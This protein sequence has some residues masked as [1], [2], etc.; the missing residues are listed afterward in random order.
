MKEPK[1]ALEGTGYKQSDIEAIGVTGYGRLTI[2]KHLNAD[3]IQE[4]LS[5]NSKEQY[6]WQIARKVKRCPGY[7]WNGQQGHHG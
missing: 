3:L 7:W 1:V 2:G 4:E 5:V 6:S